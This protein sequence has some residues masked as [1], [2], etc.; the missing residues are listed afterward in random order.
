MDTARLYLG[1]SANADKFYVWKIARGCNGESNCL[2]VASP[3]ECPLLDLDKD[4]FVVFRAYL[5]PS[6]KVEAAY[7]ETLYD[8]VIHFTPGP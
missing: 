1:D 7:Y 4:L 5:E 6:T 8:R 2:T 3:E